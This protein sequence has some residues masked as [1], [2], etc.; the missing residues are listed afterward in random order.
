MGYR[1]GWCRAAASALE[2]ARR[3]AH[4]PAVESHPG[5]ADLTFHQE[6][7]MMKMTAENSCLTPTVRK[8]N[9]CDSIVQLLL[10][11]QKPERESCDF[12]ELAGST[13]RKSLRKSIFY[14]TFICWARRSAGKLMSLTAQPTVSVTG[15][16]SEG[17]LG[18]LSFDTRRAHGKF[19]S[20]IKKILTKC[21]RIKSRSVK[22]PLLL[23]T[24]CFL[25]NHSFYLLVKHFPTVE[26]IFSFRGA[27][28][29][30]HQSQKL[31]VKWC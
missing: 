7:M 6:H 9:C 14:A 19:W 4:L 29:F 12:S 25:P 30:L 2:Q 18:C 15:L 21:C 3:A 23:H 31:S 26:D 5:S 11:R 16:N 10:F 13:E 27:V 8:M 17:R 24:K 22:Y 20:P 28:G 1:W